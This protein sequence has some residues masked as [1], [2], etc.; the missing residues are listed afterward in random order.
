MIKKSLFEQANDIFLPVFRRIP[1]EIVN[2]SGS[3]LF[4]N[5][6][7][8]YL[9]LASGLGVNALGY[10]HPEVNK[11][12]AE[13]LK[14]NMHLSNFFVQDVQ[15]ELM[16]HLLKPMPQGSQGFFSNS[17]TESVE[18]ALKLVKKWA[19]ENNKSDI[20]AMKSG[21]HGR[22]TGAV[23]VTMQEK[24]Q[25][26]FAPLLP[27]T[28]ALEFNSIESLDSCIN[29]RTAAVFFEP[30]QGEGGVRPANEDFIRHLFKLKKKYGFLVIVDEIQTGIGRTGKMFAF[31]HYNIQPDIV[32]FAKAVGGGLPLGGFLVSQELTRVFAL[33]E[34]GTTFGG[35]PLACAAGLAVVKFLT[36]DKFRHVNEVSSLLS[37]ALS[38]LD[39]KYDVITAARGIGLMQGLEIPGR[40]KE[41]QDAGLK[42]G[43]ILNSA[44]GGN[45][46]RF[47][48]PLIITENELNYALPIID[49]IIQQ[50]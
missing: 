26:P 30:I 14:R 36:R 47:L 8:K 13:Q 9:D 42:K 35:N 45:V 37:E 3:Y 46:L 28:C 17:G 23:S 19:N 22:T 40:V 31:E 29:E 27:N 34:H 6:G 43:L 1:V 21:F 20:L 38:Q 49:N 11:A 15:L 33:G 44:G 32:C 39:Q 41:I 5:K 12:I 48:P 24:Y 16:E 10:N 18:G 25:K 4:D 7:E 2:G 50:L